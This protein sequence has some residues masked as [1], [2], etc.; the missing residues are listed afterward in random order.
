MSIAK[1]QVWYREPWPWI[2]ILLPMSAVVAS[3][4]TIW[5][6]IKSEDGLV[7]DDYYKQGMAINQTLDRDLAALALGLRAEL[8][9][10]EDGQTLK[11]KLSGKL[12]PLP[13]TLKL[14]I[15]H[16]TQAGRD[17]T[18]SLQASGASVYS[19]NLQGADLSSTR[20][21]VILEAP[22]G[23]WRLTGQWRGGQ[24]TIVLGEAGKSR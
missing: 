13:D 9:V 16:P 5:L 6:A 15:L 7:A 3:I 22:G 20:W 4:I 24:P 14:S 10:A 11:L 19:A 18:L 12:T 2:L 8:N 1:K 17:K 21:R 23:D